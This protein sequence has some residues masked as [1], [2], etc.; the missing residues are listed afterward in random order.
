MLP[1]QFKVNKPFGS[2]EEAKN[3]F[4]RL[5]PCIWSSKGMESK[6]RACHVFANTFV[7][8]LVS[9]LLESPRPVTKTVFEHKCIY[10]LTNRGKTSVSG[11][12]KIQA[13]H[14]PVRIPYF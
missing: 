1:S 8:I 6:K 13:I 9:I 7:N 5:P 12:K 11:E 3:R 2:G 14:F 10:L 4:S